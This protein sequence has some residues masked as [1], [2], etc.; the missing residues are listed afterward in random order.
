[1]PITRFTTPPITVLVKG[2][3]ITTYDV[4]LTL[5]QLDT[6]ITL[7]GASLSMTATDDDTEITFS[8]TQEQAGQFSPKLPASIQVNWMDGGLRYATE[9]VKV[10]VFEN[11]LDEVIS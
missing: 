8:L 4:Y 10:R 3:D 11:L 6:E 7:S 2:Q 9:M 5:K 1:M